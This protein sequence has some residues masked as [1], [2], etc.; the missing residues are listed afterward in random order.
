MSEIKFK[1]V[2]YYDVISQ[3]Q[4]AAGKVILL[5][6]KGHQAGVMTP[7]VQWAKDNLLGAFVVYGTV[8]DMTTILDD[9]P[10]TNQS[11]AVVLTGATFPVT[12]IMHWARTNNVTVFLAH[13]ANTILPRYQILL[14][15]CV[16]QLTYDHTG[17][18]ANAT[19]IRNQELAT[20]WVVDFTEDK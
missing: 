3:G 9:L 13:D 8:D 5:T 14:P 7:V 6:L 12:E 1:D 15:S 17:R 19:T 4:L 20:G 11:I 18:V 10:A 16:V 2:R